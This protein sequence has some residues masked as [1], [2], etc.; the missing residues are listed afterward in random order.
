M[1]KL[2]WQLLIIFLT[3]LV[4]GILLLGEQPQSVSPQ[5]ATPVPVKGGV[6]TEAMVGSLLRL[7]P[8]LNFYN[9]PDRDISSLIFSGLVRFDSSGSPQPDLAETL[10]FSRDGTIYNVTLRKNARWHDGQPVTAADVLFTVDLLR[11]GSDII[12]VEGCR[13]C[14]AERSGSPI[15]PARTFR[16]LPGLSRLWNPAQAPSGREND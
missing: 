8:L 14:K 11:K 12:P 3:G 6:Y 13:G 5:A 2:R 10:G 15:P 4:V 9:S 16:S 1:K 7:N